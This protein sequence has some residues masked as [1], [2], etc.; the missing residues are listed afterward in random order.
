MHGRFADLLEAGFLISL[1]SL[2]TEKSRQYPIGGWGALTA[3]KRLSDPPR[4]RLDGSKTGV[5]F[6]SRL[7]G[8]FLRTVES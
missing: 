8:W 6:A 3:S 2:E 5:L 7:R 1:I 4:S